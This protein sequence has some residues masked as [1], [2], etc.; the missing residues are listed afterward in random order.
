MNNFLLF[1]QKTMKI[2][3]FK[4][5]LELIP[6]LR[7]IALLQNIKAKPYKGARFIIKPEHPLDLNLSSLYY[8]ESNIDDLTNLRD[9]LLKLWY[10][11]LKL[12]WL[13]TFEDDNW[14]IH[15]ILPPIVESSQLD[16][17]LSI[18]AKNE[19]NNLNSL[20]LPVLLDWHHRALLARR[21]NI[22]M[23]VLFISDID[24]AYPMYALPNSWNEFNWVPK[25][26]SNLT[27][28]KKYRVSSP[29]SL[30]RDFTN[31]IHSEF[32]E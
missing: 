14:K 24:I 6:D 13:L 2:I 17:S 1:F 32:R 11:I 27:Q 28:K 20:A 15:S 7:N 16:I 5:L 12:E 19:L 4:P 23:N 3:R 30:Y 10:D 26:P 31:L 9:S 18:D 25:V 21:L 22:T 29:K 8:L